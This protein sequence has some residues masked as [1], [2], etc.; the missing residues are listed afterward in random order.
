[1][2]EYHRTYN[3]GFE[4]ERSKVRITVRP[5]MVKYWYHF[6]NFEGDEFKHQGYRQL[7]RRKHKD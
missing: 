5:N 7:F 3:L 2:W 4:I 6:G 1:M